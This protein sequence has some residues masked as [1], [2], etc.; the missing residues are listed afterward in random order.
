MDARWR[1]RTLAGIL[2]LAIA[3]IGCNPFNLAY[4]L[5]G[6]P[7]PKI[8]PEFPL[9]DP[10]HEITVLL[11]PY[12][13]ADVQTDHLGIDRQLGTTLTRQLQERCQANREKVKIVPMHRVEKFKSEHPSWKSMGAAEIGRHF[14][15]DYVIDME[16]ISFGLYEPGSHR[17]LFKG[18]CKIDLAVLDLAR[19]QDG[20]VFK[21]AFSS[22]YPR[23]RGPVPVAD[24]NNTDKFRDMF[25]Q[26]IATDLSWLFTTHYSSE[27]Y[28]CD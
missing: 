23:T 3:G 21:K 2:T 17:T 22:E 15:A 10:R 28:Q 27:E 24:D 18:R 19:P 16:V 13:S 11:L 1:L 25:I 14:Q 8:P 12:C 4:F 9:A 7:E 26:R 5:T 20:P 6:G